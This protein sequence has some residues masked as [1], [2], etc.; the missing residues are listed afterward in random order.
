MEVPIIPQ[1]KIM[2]LLSLNNITNFSGM[3]FSTFRL[4]KGT[5]EEELFAAADDAVK[6]LMAKEEGFLGHAIL[7]GSD[8]I[9]VDVL[10][11]TSQE[12]AAQICALWVGNSFCQSYLEKIEE[13]SVNLAFYQRVK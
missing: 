11:A 2:G 6:G 8:N 4:K 3:E 12:R 7:R 13:G 9:Y 10:F 1:G 5:S